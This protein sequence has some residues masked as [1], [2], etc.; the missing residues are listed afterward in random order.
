MSIKVD[1]TKE[2]ALGLQFS[3]VE[4]EEAFVIYGDLCIK[5]SDDSYIILARGASTFAACQL[6]VTCMPLPI[7]RI[8]GP[9]EWVY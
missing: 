3:D 1:L 7:D 2:E 5:M 6:D 8:I 9:I 4:N